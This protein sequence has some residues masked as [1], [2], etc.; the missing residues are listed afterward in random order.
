MFTPTHCGAPCV[1]GRCESQAFIT[2]S[3]DNRQ[4][5]EHI[6]AET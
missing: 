1:A 3:S 2:Y 4:L 5:L 6:G